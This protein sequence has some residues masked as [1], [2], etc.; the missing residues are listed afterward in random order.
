MKKFYSKVKISLAALWVAILSFTSKV[1]AQVFEYEKLNS[2]TDYWIARVQ[3]KYWV[4]NPIINPITDWSTPM[5]IAV[6]IVQIL[7][8][9]LIPIIWVINLIKIRKIDDKSLQK[10]R[11]RKT[12]ITLLAILVTILLLAVAIRLLKKCN[13]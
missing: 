7:L 12:I 4:V 13:I 3:T 2:Q 1:F 8:I 11:I 9:I 6:K 10:K 5:I